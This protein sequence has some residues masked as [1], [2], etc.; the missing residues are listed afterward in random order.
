M[1]PTL[2]TERF[3]NAEQ[4]TIMNGEVAIYDGCRGWDGKKDLTK[5]VPHISG[6]EPGKSARLLILMRHAMPPR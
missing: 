1:D 5:G 4:L 2:F 6:D 3:P